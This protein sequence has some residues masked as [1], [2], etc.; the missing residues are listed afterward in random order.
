LPRYSDPISAQLWQRP[1]AFLRSGA[2]TF[3]NLGYDTACCHGGIPM[4]QKADVRTQEEAKAAVRGSLR[5]LQALCQVYDEGHFD[6]ERD[7]ANIIYRMIVD[8]LPQTR[9]RKELSFISYSIPPNPRNVLMQLLTSVFDARVQSDGGD[10][11]ITITHQPLLDQL[12]AQTGQPTTMKFN[13]WWSGPVLISGASD[14]PMVPTDESQQIP[15]NKR[16]RIS[17]FE[18]IRTFRNR[19]GAHYDRDVDADTKRIEDR[20]MRVMDISISRDDGASFSYFETPEV[21]RFTNS[22][23]GAIVRHVAY[24]LGQSQQHWPF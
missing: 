16:E 5:T 23:A 11:T 1:L 7:I 9:L 10:P 13:D 2:E 8:E 21:F 22:R 12:A 24:E 14:G 15:Y 18:L 3:N 19:T 6:A 20:L 4:A 17:R